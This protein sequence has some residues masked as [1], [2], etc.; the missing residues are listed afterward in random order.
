MKERL[1]KALARAGVASR[2][3]AEEMIRAGRVRVNGAVVAEMGLRVDPSTDRIEV[4][5][6]PVHPPA[7]L[8]YY[9]L[10]KPRGVV[11]T[12]RDEG[13]RRTILN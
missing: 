8:V 3:Q 10:H 11:S 7:A 9:M 2:R 1:Q 5:G 4:D 6:Q 13:G 12:V